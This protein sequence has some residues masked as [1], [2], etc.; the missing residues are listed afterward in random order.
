MTSP[1]SRWDAIVIGAGPAGSMAARELAAGGARVRRGRA[2]AVPPGE[3]L[4]RLPERP[5]SGSPGRP[6]VWRPLPSGRAASG[7]RTSGSACGV[8]WLVLACR[9]ASPCRVPG[10]MPSCSTRRSMP[11]SDSCR[12][13][14]LVSERSTAR[15]GWCTWVASGPSGRASSWPPRA[16]ARWA[17]RPAPPRGRG[18]RA[19]RGSGRLACWPTVP[20]T[21]AWG[22][23]SWRSAVSAMS[24]WCGFAMVCL[25][26]AGA[27]EPGAVRCCRRTGHRGGDDPRRGRL[28]A[29]RR[30]LDRRLAGHA[31]AHP[32]DA[33][34]RRY[35]ACS[36]SVTLRAMSSRSPAKGSPGPWRRA[37]RSHR[38]PSGHRA[39]GASSRPRLGRH[40]RSHRS[41]TP[42]DL[43][44][45]GRR[46]ATA[47]AG[48]GGLRS[49]RPAARSRGPRPPSPEC[50]ASF[51]GSEADHARDDRRDCHRPA[52]PPYR[53]VRHG[54]DRP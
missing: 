27:L 6:P 26:I 53:P 3:G 19:A 39:L 46:A 36:S 17:C 5:R 2:A 42:D 12:G 40:S 52:A 31:R 54:R 50:P 1:K 28:P 37:G 20:P 22:P 15:L 13:P 45:H 43:S 16:S 18:S 32:A 38:W 29:G 48:P 9:P 34:A 4:R 47:L 7:C 25:H 51:R 23:S 10:S 33:P 44:R 21:T 35:R 11:A 8:E 41:P 49:A 24:A 30:A 14:R